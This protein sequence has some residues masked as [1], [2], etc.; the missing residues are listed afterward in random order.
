MTANKQPD[1]YFVA[2]NAEELLFALD[3]SESYIVIPKAF[4][5]EFLEKTQLPLTET[6]QMGFEL[7]FRGTANLLSSPFFHLLNWLSDDSKQQKQIDSKVRK[8]SLK[9][10]EDEVILYL[11]QLDF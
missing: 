11:R 6:G 7:G 9:K 8:Y 1:K 4:K 10:Q 3:N 5:E 2:N